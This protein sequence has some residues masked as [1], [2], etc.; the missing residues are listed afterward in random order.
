MHR[1]GHPVTVLER[2]P[3]PDARPPGG[4]LDLHEGM[5]QLALGQGGAAGGLPGAVAP[6]GTGH[7]H[8]GHGRDRPA[9]LAA[10]VRA[11]GPIRDRPGGNSVTCC[12]APSTFVGPGRDGGGAGDPRRR[13]WSVSR[14]G[15]RRRSTS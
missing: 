15:G 13:C 9:R 5:G 2:D 6:R 1:H 3:A 8:P 14:T 7:A 11:T 12:S 4:T 10:P